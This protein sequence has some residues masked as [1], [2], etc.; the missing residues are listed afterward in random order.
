MRI[1]LLILLLGIS[2]LLKGQKKDTVSYNLATPYDAVITH[3]QYLQPDSYYPEI[4]SK[5]L[6]NEGRSN[7][8]IVSLSIKLK[9]IFDGSGEE[10]EI[11][12]IP[13]TPN[14]IDSTNNRARY[15]VSKKFPDL[16][17]EKYGS[18]WKYS[19]KSVKKIDA[20]HA[21]IYPFGTAKLLH[22][23]PPNSGGFKLFG[24]WGWQLAGILILIIICVVLHKI[25]TLVIEK[26][27]IQILLRMGYRKLADE[28]VIPVA[29]P[30]SFLIIFP[31]LIVFVP[32]LQLPIS[33]SKYVIIALKAIW[34]VFAIVFF[35]RLV[36]I[37]SLYLSKM[38]E[39]TESTLDD[40]LV[41]LLR[42][43]L[44]TFVVIVGGLFI[45]DNLEFDITGL[46]AGISIGGLAFALAAQD[47]IK[48]FFGSLM[49]F[50]DRPFQVGDWITSGDVDGTVEE[51]GFRSTRIRTFRNSVM[52]IPNGVITNQMIDNHGLRVYR[53]FMTNISLTYDTPPDLIEVFVDGLKEIVKK[54]PKTRKDYYEIHFNNMGASS[55]DV[56]FYIF[57]EVP[58]WTEELRSRHEVLLEVVKLAE[59]LGVNFAFP[60]QT[61]HVETFPEK[62]GNSPEYT[63]NTPELRK[64]LEEFLATKRAQ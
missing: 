12:E 61:L 50:V 25:F 24:L 45:L 10:I 57:F 8:E 38:A 9:Q 33:M 60:T 54:H 32:V 59:N 3:L 62:K 63:K 40:Q 28:V 26:L 19:A 49:I 31:I 21:D 36:D 20:L 30:I 58:T 23:L 22:L 13:R 7:E 27:I 11:D 17:L 53:R 55:L 2:G 37:F 1:T 39:K 4:A 43:V 5:A 42:K 6:K 56:L 34:P 48:N 44:K 14:Y 51:V 18:R 47:T 41:P 35:Y 46:I 16:Y 29:K 52:Y 15:I 64:K